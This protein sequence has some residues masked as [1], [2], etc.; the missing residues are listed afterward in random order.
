MFLQDV[1]T[2]GMTWIVI[3]VETGPCLCSQLSETCNKI[4]LPASVLASCE[5]ELSFKY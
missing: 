5:P 4:H 3:A 1:G 2:N